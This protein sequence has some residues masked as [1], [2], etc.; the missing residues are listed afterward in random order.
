M[1]NSLL[2]IHNQT[3][4]ETRTTWM[5]VCYNYLYYQSTTKLGL[6]PDFAKVPPSTG[7]SLLPIHNQTRIE[8]VLKKTLKLLCKTLLPIHNQ[9]RIE[10]SA[11]DRISSTIALFTTNPQPN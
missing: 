8:T 5:I 3:R 9:T 6:K 10:T 7:N 11:V 4:I 1:K 2:P